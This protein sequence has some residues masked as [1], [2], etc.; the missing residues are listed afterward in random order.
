MYQSCLG[1][2]DLINADVV[3]CLSF[4]IVMLN[5][6]LH[7]NNLK[8]ET[9]MTLSD[10]VKYN[11]LYNKEQTRPLKKELLEGIYHSIKQEQL[12]VVDDVRKRRGS[13]V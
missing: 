13:Q 2:E 10:F 3:Y 8:E 12:M 11:T 9:K 6:D 1:K 5:T 4:A 7:N